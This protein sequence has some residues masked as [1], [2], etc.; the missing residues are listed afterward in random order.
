MGQESFI[1]VETNAR[2]RQDLVER[3]F[4]RQPLRVDEDVARTL[5]ALAHAAWSVPRDKY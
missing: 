2:S 5:E 1:P 4:S 3:G